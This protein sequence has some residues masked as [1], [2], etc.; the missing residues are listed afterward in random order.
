MSPAS[1]SD[2]KILAA[3][4]GG[5]IAVVIVIL[6]IFV[7]VRRRLSLRDDDEEPEVELR[8]SLRKDPTVW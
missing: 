6:I 1:I 7:L 5:A 2:I 8:E 3:S 4:V